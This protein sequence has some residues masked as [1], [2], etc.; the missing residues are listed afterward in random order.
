MA[1][2]YIYERQQHH[3]ASNIASRYC[4]EWSLILLPVTKSVGRIIR[5]K[6]SRTVQV[7]FVVQYFFTKVK[8]RDATK[9]VTSLNA[10][11]LLHKCIGEHIRAFMFFTLHMCLS[12]YPLESLPSHCNSAG[13]TECINEQQPCA[14]STW[15]TTTAPHDAHKH[16]YFS[17]IACRIADNAENC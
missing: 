13:L 12:M 14:C 5:T 2:K 11:R 8:M 6:S 7:N 10:T 15:R 4:H 16:R 9:Y 17:G 1:N 3:P